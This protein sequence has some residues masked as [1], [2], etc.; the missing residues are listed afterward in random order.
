MGRI[1]FVIFF[2]SGGSS[3]ILETLWIRL[4]TLV[5][6]STTFAISTVVAAFMG[7]LALGSYLIGRFADEIRRPFLLY[8]LC[9]GAIGL[10]A[11]LLPVILDRIPALLAPLWSAEGQS[12]YVLSL[13][14]FGVV[15]LLLLIPTTLMGGTL[16]LLSTCRVIQRREIGATVGTL[17]AVNT[18]GAIAGTAICGF[19]LL[20]V[21]GVSTTNLLAAG[22]DLALCALVV[23]LRRLETD[24]PRGVEGAQGVAPTVE[25][26]GRPPSYPYV[27]AAFALSGFAALIYQIVWS[28]SLTLVIGSSIY[29][30]TILLTTFLVGLALGSAV[31]VRRHLSD[32]DPIGNLAMIQLLIGLFGFAGLRFIDRLPALFLLLLQF[33]SLSVPVAFLL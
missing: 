32:P 14:R 21:I 16:P 15:F 11:L 33:F 22:I 6:G 12:F 31:Y 2:F 17:Y 24:L 10:Y 29:A 30:Y 1:V 20:P 26:V 25:G 27:A 23:A 28:R 8:G 3:L 9:E 13:I 19:L 5:F 4:L 7:G 18:F